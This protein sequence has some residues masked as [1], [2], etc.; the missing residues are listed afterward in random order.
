MPTTENLELETAPS[1]GTVEQLPPPAAPRETALLTYAQYNPDA[2]HSA[3]L[4]Y[5]LSL[6]HI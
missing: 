6:I 5:S 3:L 1:E 2:A 4:A